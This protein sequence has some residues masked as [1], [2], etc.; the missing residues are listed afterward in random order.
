MIA[1]WSYEQAEE[2]INAEAQTEGR[3]RPAGHGLDRPIVR[4]TPFLW[5]D[6][7]RIPRREWLYGRHLIRRF[8]SATI[9]PGG[10][11]K[12]SLIV[13]EA[14]AMV[15]G[16]S[17]LG[18]QPADRLR[19][20]QVNLEDPEDEL[21][22]RVAAAALHHGIS[23]AE[24]AD[25]LYLDSGRKTEV[26]IATE[27]RDGIEIAIPVVEAIKAEIIANGIDV[28]QVD[29]FV[30]CHAVSENDNTKIAAVVHE[31][32]AI[33]E[34]TNC[35][36]DLVHHVRKSNGG[37]AFTVED[38]RGASALIAAVR[39]GRVLNAM[40]KEEAERAD[41]E[42]PT[43]YFSVASGKANLAPRG[44]KATWCHIVG[45]PLG[46]GT[47]PFDPAG[48]VVGVVEPW[49][50]PDAFAEVSSDDAKEVQRRIAQGEWRADQR[51]TSWAG[52]AIAEVLGLDLSQPAVRA[53]VK[54]LLKTWVKTG[55]LREV[56]RKDGRRKPRKF[57]E[58]GE[59]FP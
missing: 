15:S 28:M 22:R 52:V 20:W 7:A 18:N 58:I 4:A 48:D 34:A 55:A 16:R 13:T 14:L 31:W 41:I 38:A 45:V 39:S 42:N 46:N 21:Q 1:A 3:R 49:S 51:C 2:E 30:A 35:A 6:P 29:P 36:I 25:R 26:I 57:V 50:W 27:S 11:G 33:A 24:I 54:T 17:L 10:L 56:A 59:A 8:P 44:D 9:A 5:T 12:S 37:Q 53:T 47:P 43:S 19:V 32:A 40:S 23:P